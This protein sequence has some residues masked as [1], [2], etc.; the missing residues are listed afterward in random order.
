MEPC[1]HAQMLPAM[2]SL[3]LALSVY[4][5]IFYYYSCSPAEA[6]EGRGTKG[7][8]PKKKKHKPNEL[9]YLLCFV[10]EN[11]MDSHG[12][13]TVLPC[14]ALPNCLSKGESSIFYR[15]QMSFEDPKVITSFFFFPSCYEFFLCA[16]KILCCH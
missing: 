11:I 10:S 2:I 3:P 14:I 12:V 16:V 7:V 15:I 5:F 6:T 4:L 9:S 1:W 13:F 8:L